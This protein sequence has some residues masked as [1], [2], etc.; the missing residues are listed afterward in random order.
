[1]AENNIT[2]LF[3]IRHGETEANLEKRY[4]GLTDYGLN[5][6]GISQAEKV[7][8]RLAR[9]P[10][11]I[12]YSSTL[13]RARETAEK[14]AVHHNLEVITVETLK[15]LNFGNWEGLTAEEI[16]RL[17]PEIFQKWT[18]GEFDIQIPGGENRKLFLERINQAISTI[19]E[20]H[21]G[22]TVAVVTHGGPIKSII[23]QS[24]GTEPRAFWNFRQD[25]GAI[26]LIE[27]NQD[28]HTVMFINDTCHLNDGTIYAPPSF[29]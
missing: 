27:Y 24:L 15:E 13:K 16:G 4:Q 5:E 17:Y 9:E 21:Q 25:N 3:L 1:M 22:Q 11:S 2:R 26:N 6:R 10:L 19:I 20:E 7:G 18:K 29:K 23:C 28:Y 12:I 14:I 8:F